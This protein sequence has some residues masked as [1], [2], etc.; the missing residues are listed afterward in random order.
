[1][2]VIANAMSADPLT[3][4]DRMLGKIPMKGSQPKPPEPATKRYPAEAFPSNA[5]KRWGE[6]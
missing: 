2:A 5:T 4:L 6:R 3:D 1:M